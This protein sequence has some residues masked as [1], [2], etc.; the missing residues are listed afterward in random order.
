MTGRCLICEIVSGERE[1]GSVAYRTEDVVAFPGMQQRAQNPAHMQ[2][3]PVEHVETIYTLRPAALGPLIEAVQL[4]ARAVKLAFSADGVIIHQHN[5]AAGGQ[6]VPHVHF[7]V[8]PRFTG[9]GYWQAVGN[10]S[11]FP[12]QSEDVLAAQADR[13][14]QAIEKLIAAE[15]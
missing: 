12:W 14:H 5:E 10:E 1:P 4:V 6:H 9:D 15:R 8:V 13:V 11:N 7:H 3:V 2:V